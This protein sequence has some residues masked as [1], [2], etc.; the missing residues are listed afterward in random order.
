VVAVELLLS[1]G[2]HLT[3]TWLSAA[4]V[5]MAALS[6]VV[7]L[8]RGRPAPPSFRPAFAACREAVRDPVVAVLAVAV[9]GGLAYA[10]ALIIGTAPN[11]YDALWYHLARA[12]FW[13]QQ[14]AI[15][16]IPA[17]NDARLNG[18]PPNG[19]I[20]DSFTMILG[21]SERFVGFVQFSALVAAT[22]AIGGIAR[23]IGLSVRQALFGALLFATLPVVVLQS[24]TALND[25][26]FAALLLCS[27]YFLFT[28]T[29]VSLA[30]AAL[31]LGVAIGT[32]ITALLGLPLLAVLGAVLYPRRRWPA[33]L[34]VG[35]GGVALGSYWYLFNLA[36]TG[37]LGGRFA[38]PQQAVFVQK[39]NTYSFAG[40]VAHLMRLVIDAVDPSGAAGRDRF[41]YLVGAA[42]VLVLGIRGRRRFGWISIV[43]AVAL[44]ALPL[45]FR[46]IDHELLHAY[47]KLWVTL[48]RPDLAFLG[49]DK[50]LTAPSPFQSW[51]GAVGL[52]L[53]LGGFVL[54]WR[55]IRRGTLP[56]VAIVL[57]L[58]PVV[59]I[60][61]QAVTTFYSIFD[62]RYA[63]FGVALAAAVWGLVLPFRPLAWAATAVAVTALVLVLVH[64]DEKPSG[65]N[66]LGGSA[67]TSVWDMSRAQVL[68]RFLHPGETDVLA[69]L[70]RQARKGD[71][72]AIAIRRE[73]ASY[74]YF[75]S[76]LD[77]RVV[78]TGN[79]RTG[80][81]RQTPTGATWLVLAPHFSLGSPRSAHAQSRSWRRVAGRRGWTLYRRV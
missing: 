54:V 2:H 10:S 33:L 9:L 51:Y 71:T 29:R 21:R 38:Q 72:I 7:W 67:P 78:F 12:A 5:V 81:V 79:L 57:A 66:V 34:L 44:A 46:V 30:L 6:A 13:K 52:L 20:A 47:Q 32:K 8:L 28:W 41:L 19:E 23:R 70:E 11:D 40:T 42:V 18:F 64:Y 27:A 14:H 53:V 22:I 61:L 36:K 50:H 80:V 26:V 31:A 17:A 56:R 49:Y 75:G 1:P 16:Y 62:G 77:R 48:D 63:I 43:V 3:A 39:G 76:R 35:A 24:T 15:A 58:A 45:A 69:T 68:G 65:V 4:L 55:G 74:P 59:W 73:D 37:R 60:V 25:L